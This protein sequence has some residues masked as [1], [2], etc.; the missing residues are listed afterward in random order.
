MVYVN[1]DPGLFLTWAGLEPI[2][3]EENE[4]L[5]IKKIVHKKSKEYIDMLILEQCP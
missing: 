3:F 4:S 5:F 1:V 2:F